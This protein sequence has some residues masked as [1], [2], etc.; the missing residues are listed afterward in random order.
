MKKKLA[1]NWVDIVL[2]VCMSISTICWI[3]LYINEPEP[4]NLVKLIVTPI[5]L[6]LYILLSVISKL[7][8]NNKYFIVYDHYF[9]IYG[10]SIFD[11]KLIKEHQNRKYVKYGVTCTSEKIYQFEHND[12]VFQF[13]LMELDNDRTL[14]IVYKTKQS[15]DACWRIVQESVDNAIEHYYQL[16]AI[17]PLDLENVFYKNKRNAFVITEK[18]DGTFAVTKHR[19]Y[20]TVLF[21][22]IRDLS[23]CSPCW[24]EIDKFCFETRE[25]AE[26]F[27]RRQ[28]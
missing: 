4:Y 27:V 28:L 21:H 22:M 11:A 26:E 10:K 15:P 25:F 18:A 12:L 19:H 13:G 1:L 16:H 14:M 5:C 9:T 24:C 17:Q 23:N 3:S 7:V 2:I 8:E 20:V 6:V